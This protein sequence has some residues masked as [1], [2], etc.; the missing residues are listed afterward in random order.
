MID[1]GLNAA[2]LVAIEALDTATLLTDPTTKEALIGAIQLADA[3][4]AAATH[5]A[6]EC[7]MNHILQEQPVES[8]PYT[9]PGYVLA[10]LQALFA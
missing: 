3:D 10:D 4:C 6:I 9:K 8:G 7:E 2:I 5:G 1:P